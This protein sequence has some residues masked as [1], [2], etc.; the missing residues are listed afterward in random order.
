[1]LYKVKSVRVRDAVPYDSVSTVTLTHDKGVL[2]Y[3]EAA[4]LIIATPRKAGS[5]AKSLVIPMGNVVFFEIL[6]EKALAA[7]VARKAAISAEPPPAPKETK[8]DVIKLEKG[9][10]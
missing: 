9:S 1:M 8:S 4:Q 6:D 5:L 7:D 3:D 10:R 2:E